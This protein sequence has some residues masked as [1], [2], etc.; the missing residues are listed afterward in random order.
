MTGGIGTTVIS[1]S[2]LH[3]FAVVAG[4]GLLP[5]RAHRLANFGVVDN[6]VTGGDATKTG[7]HEDVPAGHRRVR[8]RR[9][10]RCPRWSRAGPD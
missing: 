7:L 3:R 9:R 4:V 6:L 8:D 1:K 10:A 2:W 5:I